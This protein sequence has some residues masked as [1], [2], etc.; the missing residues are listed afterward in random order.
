MSFC[1][2]NGGDI[3]ICFSIISPITIHR[4]IVG[5][6]S[7]NSFKVLLLRSVVNKQVEI[8]KK[9]DVFSNRSG[10]Y[11]CADT[12]VPHSKKKQREIRF[13]VVCFIDQIG[14][15]HRNRYKYYY[16]PG[17]I[18][19]STVSSLAGKTRPMKRIVY[20][21]NN[22]FLCSMQRYYSSRRYIVYSYL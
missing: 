20:F 21:T 17:V 2:L 3:F 7:C 5:N 19:L 4:D 10:G 16:F 12:R 9:R 13:G 18:V 8:H 22:D 1:S 11:I 15:A 14:C 6:A